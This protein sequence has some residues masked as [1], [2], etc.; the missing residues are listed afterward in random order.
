MSARLASLAA[1]AVA[2]VAVILIV[3]GGGPSYTVRIDFQDAGQLIAGDLVEVGGI[4]VGTVQSL[5]LTRDNEAQVTVALDRG[6]FTPLHEGTTASVG[7]V[8]LSGVTNR[9]V[10]LAPGPP[11]NAA[12]P[13]NGVIPESDTTPIV[14]IDEVLDAVTPRVRENLRHW[15][16]ESAGVL[17]TPAA[18]AGARQTLDYAAAAIERSGA[19]IDQVTEDRAAFSGLIRSGAATAAAIAGQQTALTRGVASTASAL[20]AIAQARTALAG[21]L[22][23]A[24]ATL[25]EGTSFLTRLRPALIALE[26]V[27]RDA[28]PVAAPLATVLTKLVPVARATAPVLTNLDA[29]LPE[30]DAAFAALPRVSRAAIPALTETVT[31][32]RRS[33]PIF[34]GIR[35]YGEDILLGIL[36]GYGGGS[37]ENYDANGQFSRIALGLP[38][39]TLLTSILGFDIHQLSPHFLTEQTAKCPG[40]AAEPAPDRSNVITVPGCNPKETP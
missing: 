17:D 22:T 19:F 18:V 11:S 26:P 34:T 20:A 25:T 2:F 7:T 9:F 27:L 12:I 36:H 23:Q 30:L 33:L 40:S 16:Q 1:L 38:G 4:P 21:S 6:R 5:Q 35:P 8:G 37:A 24:P 28:Q 10:A 39:P 31:A 14:D 13:S 32:L 3:T 29:I 15:I